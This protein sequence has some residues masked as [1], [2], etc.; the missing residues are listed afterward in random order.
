M[1]YALSLPTY[2]QCLLMCMRPAPSTTIVSN[3]RLVHA[4][5]DERTGGGWVILALKSMCKTINPR[6]AINAKNIARCPH[7][8]FPHWAACENTARTAGSHPLT[9]LAHTSQAPVCPTKPM[10]PHFQVLAPAAPPKAA[11]TTARAKPS[12]ACLLQP[13]QWPPI[14]IISLPSCNALCN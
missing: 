1:S 10:V 3:K 11:G 2:V 13:L 5:A 8:P 9:I 6:T 14:T 7:H 4:H 12:T